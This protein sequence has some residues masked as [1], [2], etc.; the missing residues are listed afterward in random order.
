MAAI[1]RSS[2]KGRFLIVVSDV[3]RRL[4]S[5]SGSRADNIAVA[6]LEL[7]NIG[8][9]VAGP[10]WLKSLID[11]FGS[12]S[13]SRATMLVLAALFVLAWA[14]GGIVATWRLVYSTRVIDRLTG[15]LIDDVLRS[16]LPRS[17]TD[18][19]ADS[20]QVLG[21]L[22]RLPF[23]LLVVVDGLLWR[24]APLLV[25][26]VL[27]LAVVAMIMPWPYSASLLVVLAGHVVVSWFG[28]VRH[29][30]HA[31]QAVQMAAAVS[32]NLGDLLRNARRVVFNGALR[33]E[34][35]RFAS[36]VGEKA[37]ANSLMMWSLV[38]TAALQ[39]G[40]LGLGLAGLLIAG[41][42]DVLAS[43][44]SLGDFVMLETYAL[45]LAIPLSSAGFILVQSATAV[46]MVAQVLDH[47]ERSSEAGQAPPPCFPSG[48]AK[49]QLS[50]ICFRYPG[51]TSGIEDISFILEPGSFNVIVGSNGSGKS[52]LAQVIAGICR[53]EKGFVQI[54]DTVLNNVRSED[55]HHWVL[56]VPQFITL[57]SR[58][59][60]ANALYSPTSLLDDELIATLTRWRFYVEG[61]RIDLAQ[62]VG[63]L[64]ERLSGGQVQKLE[65]ARLTGVT[66]PVLVLDESTSALDP[67]SESQAL[68]DLRS[69]L[70]QRTTI[71]MISH[72]RTVVQL[73]DHVLFMASGRLVGQGSHEYLMRTN[74]AYNVLWG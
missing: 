47:A 49:V 50:N 15:D 10:F 48:A 24:L 42:T 2:G 66:V 56:Y 25:Q 5:T 32:S 36:I 12:E 44:M 3:V 34:R 21:L 18:R 63:E 17:A 6:V 22:E 43:R 38:R 54:D 46:G 14:G 70:G 26:A 19:D 20:G 60:A 11:G 73:A 72:R 27:S 7:I 37:G 62:H 4:A 74:R 64:G 65:L 71:V 23:S 51:S 13:S 52:T 16:E 55:R 28:A 40:W 45:R 67:A 58:P 69:C 41:T 31:D 30:D 59:L 8:L 35:D 33:L 68:T 61:R 57:L 53:T 29:G 9:G 39:Y 1:K